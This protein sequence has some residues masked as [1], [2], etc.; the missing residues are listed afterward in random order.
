MPRI[1]RI[2]VTN[3]QYDYAKKQFPDL[4]FDLA[5]QDALVL[6]TNGGGKTLLLQLI[7][8]VVLPN[9]RL[10]GRRIVEL[11]HSSKYTGHVAVEWLLDSSGD[12]KDYVCTGFCFTSGA[13]DQFRYFNYLFDYPK[14]TLG[15]DGREEGLTI[16]SLPLVTELEG[17]RRQPIRY[18]ELR[19]WLRSEARQQVQIFDQVQSYQERL[20]YY[21]ILPE[22]WRNIR[23]T[24]NTEGGV[25]RFF[26]RC[27]TTAQ[28][29]DNLLIPS[30]EQVIFRNESKK[31]ELVNAFNEYKVSLLQIPVIKQNIA[32]FEVV[33]NQAEDVVQ[34]VQAL[35]DR[36]KE[37]QR[38]HGELAVLAKTF[39]HHIQGASREMEGLTGEIEDKQERKAELD[40]KIASYRV[41]LKELEYKDAE[42]KEKGRQAEYQAAEEGLGQAEASANQLYALYSYNQLLKAQGELAEYTAR[43]EALDVAEPELMEQLAA[44][45]AEMAWA[46]QAEEK[47]FARQI[48]AIQK[49]IQELEKRLK[50]ISRTKEDQQAQLADLHQEQG[51]MVA[52]LDRYTR[53]QRE[54]SESI[55]EFSK[56]DPA[57]T[58]EFYTELLSQTEKRLQSAAAWIDKAEEQIARG[59]ERRLELK[60][61]GRDLNANLQKVQDQLASYEQAAEQAGA[62]LAARSI[63]QLPVL[64]H[65]DSIILKVRELWEASQQN[66]I[67]AQASLAN[68]EEKWALLQGRDSYLP[69]PVM[70]QLK[71]ELA[72]RGLPVLLGS[73]WL[74]DHPDSDKEREEYLHNHP[75]LPFC[76]IVEKGQLHSV[77]QAARTLQDLPA[78][79]P[80][81]FLVRQ[82]LSPGQG[83]EE[84]SLQNILPG[85]LYTLLGEEFQLYTSA[86]YF[87]EFKE[88]MAGQLGSE[89]ERLQ[90]L[91]G[92]AEEITHLRGEIES[93]YRN[94]SLEL[95]QTWRT[96]QNSLQLALKTNEVQLR[97]LESEQA[98]LLT[99]IREAKTV[100]EKLGAEKR[101]TEKYLE[102][103]AEFL[104]LHG[105]YAEQRGKQEFLVS[106]IAL[107]Q[108]QIARWDGE[109][110]SLHG[111]KAEKTRELASCQGALESHRHDFAAY[112]LKEVEPEETKAAYEQLKG[113]VAGILEKLRGR[114]SDRRDLEDLC[115]RA[116]SE[117]EA[118]REE[119]TRRGVH[120][121]SLTNIQRTVSHGELREADQRLRDAQAKAAACKE[122]W[123]TA[124][125][126]VATCQ[127]V[128]LTLAEGI[129]SS[130]GKDPYLGYDQVLHAEEVEVC[131]SS[132]RQVENTLSDLFA[133]QDKLAAWQLENR[134][135][136][137]QILETYR[138]LVQASWKQVT[139]LTQEEWQKYG[140]RPRAAVRQVQERRHQ[141]SGE[142]ETHKLKV[143]QAFHRYREELEKT[144]NV[145]VRQFVREIQSIV[146]EGRLYD[147]DFV[148]T[149]FIRI[150]EA[151]AAYKLQYEKL[152]VESEQNFT[153]LV[154][155]CTRRALTI[156]ES[157]LEIPKNSRI[158][159]YGRTLQLLVMDWPTNSE[160]ENKVRM[161][162][163]LADVIDKMQTWQQDG[164]DDDELD[165]RLGDLLRTRSL[166]NVLAPIENCRVQV[167]KP[168]SESLIRHQRLHHAP[169][170]DV[171]RWSGG[172]N[173]SAYITM[174]MVM[175]AHIRQQ[176]EGKANSWKVLVADNP[177]GKASADHVLDPIFEVAKAN[178]IQLLC[179]TAHKEESILRYF[180]VVYSLQLRQTYGKEIIQA[181]QLE[182][183]FYQREAAYHGLIGEDAVSFEGS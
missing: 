146:A 144:N 116:A 161:E 43:L 14:P 8:Q 159:L 90:E 12:Q 110:A 33:Q 88:K 117:A 60:L 148:E 165:A 17:G 179:F 9:E 65:R 24:N 123:W 66:L 47:Q 167:Y 119:I 174:F 13:D 163:Y 102:L 77:R 15:E 67:L 70:L 28:L 34:V 166:L 154:N 115:R 83:Q 11:L 109:V 44:V 137:E 71:Q 171:S 172:E 86:E 175:L 75:L 141:V 153:H 59:E 111:Q 155:L 4:I 40:W 122:A 170:D 156:Y 182:S 149:Q 105:E 50:Q 54:L 36:Q 39:D 46:W 126:H 74:A 56:E 49:L 143:N 157:I 21:H 29:M 99:E 42:L 130:Y 64:E 10:Q 38:L 30:V 114:Q 168:R 3:I 20:R 96:E 151:I 136:Y 85:E 180:P 6:L 81:L 92:R 63:F 160:E 118:A 73:E 2:R 183:G 16:A 103:L 124:R 147:F 22:E 108:T 129:Q 173:Y 113:Q 61:A 82:S 169:W 23:D 176:M 181:E 145:R 58:K 53:R 98:A 57:S 125:G 89:K 131:K 112:G 52:W 178:Q 158:G 107:L 140:L 62:L 84:G 69:H 19:D 41:Y 78:D 87:R 80:L 97:E 27:R 101:Q 91:R 35:D 95:V 48:E 164:M 132:L 7:M 5:E 104:L 100:L 120:I 76:L 135:A 127:E 138:D 128:V 26:E 51:S 45:K 55:P 142:V 72:K 133:R 150:F 31:Q 37:L 106:E 25:D 93:F 18:Q 134:E 139:P 162:Q 68:R 121:E 94:Y 1:N 32:D 177:F 79:F 152:L